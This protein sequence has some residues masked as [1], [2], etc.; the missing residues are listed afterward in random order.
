MLTPEE[1]GNILLNPYP[2]HTACAD[3]RIGIFVFF[4]QTPSPPSD[5]QFQRNTHCCLLQRAGCPQCQQTSHRFQQHPAKLSLT[6]ELA[7]P[8]LR[9]RQEAG[10]GRQQVLFLKHRW[11][12][13]IKRGKVHKNMKKRH[14]FFKGGSLSCSPSGRNTFQGLPRGSMALYNRQLQNPQRP[15]L[16][17][18]AFWHQCSTFHIQPRLLPFFPSCA[19]ITSCL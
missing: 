4:P 9:T 10:W 5:T 1:L 13:T 2:V 15:R 7:S 18:C 12:N 19:N 11:E 14:S 3:Q 16:E 17:T 8:H 6:P